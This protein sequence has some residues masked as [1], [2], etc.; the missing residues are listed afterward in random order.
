MTGIAIDYVWDSSRQGYDKQK[1]DHNLNWISG[2]AHKWTVLRMSFSKVAGRSQASASS[3]PSH[4]RTGERQLRHPGTMMKLIA[5]RLVGGK[6]QIGYRSKV[7]R[8]RQMGCER[9]GSS[10]T[11]E[12]SV[13]CHF[14][15]SVHLTV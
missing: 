8:G 10:I 11:L 13:A 4:A 5:D 14:V 2:P 3:Q 1:D 9:R 12:S 7:S 6:G 15:S